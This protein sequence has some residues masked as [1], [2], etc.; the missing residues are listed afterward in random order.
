MYTQRKVMDVSAAYN[1]VMNRQDVDA[2][3]LKEQCMEVFEESKLVDL[4][5]VKVMY[6][7]D[8][9]NS[10][11]CQYTELPEMVKQIIALVVCLKGRWF[12]DLHN[13]R[14]TIIARFKL[15]CKPTDFWHESGIFKNDE[16]KCSNME[17]LIEKIIK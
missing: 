8:K 17:E 9:S 14:D 4:S 7:I 1:L 3:S 10:H 12:S 13:G 11:Y 6:P 5:N 15:S 16:I 2:R